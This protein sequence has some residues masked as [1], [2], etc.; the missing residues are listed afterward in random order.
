MDTR[1]VTT[2]PEDRL[3]DTLLALDPL[4]ELPR[5]GWLL[6]GIRP[7]ESIAE[8]SYGVAVVAMML[9]DRLRSD[10]QSVDGERVLRLALLHDA[11]EARTGD[12]PMPSKTPALRGALH[13]LE[14]RLA[15]DLLP[16]E[17]FAVWR[18]AEQGESLEARVVAAADKLQMMIKVSAYEASGRGNLE[19]FWHNPKNFRMDLPIARQVFARICERAGRSLPDE[20]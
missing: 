2:T 7:C 20:P 19:E 8:H 16:P 12:I 6:R 17:L 4:S 14:E 10:G 18:E 9:V 1:A 5:T 15:S 13:E 3:I 11:P